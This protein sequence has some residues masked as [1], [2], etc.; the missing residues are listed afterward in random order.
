MTGAGG[1]LTGKHPMPKKMKVKLDNTDTENI[2]H[3]YGS[4]Q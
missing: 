1:F 3:Y 2:I 4:F